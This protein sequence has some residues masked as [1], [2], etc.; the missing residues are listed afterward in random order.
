MRLFL[1]RKNRL[2]TP[3]N[4][5]FMMAHL[6]HFLIASLF[7]VNILTF[8]IPQTSINT[9]FGIQLQVKIKASLCQ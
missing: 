1:V 4:I 9:I 7:K 8:N 3:Q 5:S 2:C 6:S